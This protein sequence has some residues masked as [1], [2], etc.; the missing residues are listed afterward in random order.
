MAFLDLIVDTD[1]VDVDA[2]ELPDHILQS[3]SDRET[4]VPFASKSPGMTFVDAYHP[5]DDPNEFLFSYK[6]PSSH[7]LIQ[8]HFP[9]NPVMMGVCQWII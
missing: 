4:I 7:P 2:I 3:K 1:T 6:Y 9:G 5:L 8:G